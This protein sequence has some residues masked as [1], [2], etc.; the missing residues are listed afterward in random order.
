MKSRSILLLFIILTLVLTVGC[1]SE[2]YELALKLKEGKEYN[3]SNNITQVINQEIMGNKISMEQTIDMLYTFVVDQIDAEG[4]YTLTTEY[5]SLDI[6]INKFKSTLP[7][8]QQ[9]EINQEV[10]NAINQ[11]MRPLLNKKFTIKMT[12]RGEIIEILGYEELMESMI[13]NMPPG[14]NST[15]VEQ[16]KGFIDKDSIKQTWQENLSYLPNEPV[17]LGESWERSLTMEDPLPITVIT[18]YTLE[19][20]DQNEVVIKTEGSIEM[21][22]ID[23]SQFLGTAVQEGIEV[24]CDFTGDQTGSIILDIN[25]LWVKNM[26]VEQNM[27]GKIIIT[28]TNIDQSIEM[29]MEVIS[30]SVVTGSN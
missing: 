21:G 11:M 17:N 9:E 25:S 6:G 26:E 13:E 4:N 18:T 12:N 19:S 27:S 28:N 10:N 15:M 7:Q 29:P 2:D 1:I 23:F 24:D 3:L 14:S 20:V 5:N 16:I 30:K 22:N 8:V